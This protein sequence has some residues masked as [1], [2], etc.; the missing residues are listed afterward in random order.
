[1][2][3]ISDAETENSIRSYAAPLFVAAGLDPDAVRI[4][5]IQDNSLNAFVTGGQNI[6]IHT[7]LLMAANEVG[8]VIGVIAH[9]T[10]HIAGGHL[11]RGA[12][13]LDKARNIGIIS[14]ILGV[15][16][17]LLSGRGDV[18]A[19]ATIGSQQSATRNLLKYSRTQESTADQS[20]L[21]YL[22]TVG[23]SAR[24]MYA[25]LK[26]IENQELL[27]ISRQDPYMRT[28]PMSGERLN[29]IEAHLERSKYSNTDFPL[30][31][32]IQHKRIQAK[33]Y[34]YT[35]PLATVL[36]RYPN[37]DQ[38]IWARYARAFA[39]YRKPDLAKA[40]TLIDELLAE[41]PDDPYFHEL[42]AQMLFEHGHAIE[43]L[44]EYQRA[45]DL[46]P[47]TAVLFRELGQAQLASEDPA[48]LGAAEDNLRHALALERNAAGTWHQLAIVYGRQD[49]MGHYSLALAEEFLLRRN[50]KDAEY[51]AG[52]AASMFP[53]GTPEWLQAEDIRTAAQ[54]LKQSAP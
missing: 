35:Y 32:R 9:E 25:F 18:A 5:L 43:A 52:K 24:G 46:A 44:P 49:K 23:Q 27:S 54:N 31:L 53:T 4:R 20:A 47:P 15:G 7:G 3:V 37:S 10:G 33:I 38:S 16:A 29:A 51:H 11:I 1:M 34:A 36:R 41:L 39:Y 42:K 22:D 13:A 30:D 26:T 40:I 19:A 45:V 28:H 17:G 50:I 6:F 48:L 8:E 2:I 12:Q 21:K 14:S